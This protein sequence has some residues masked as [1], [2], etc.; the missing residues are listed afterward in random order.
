MNR[1]HAAAILAIGLVCGLLAK[2]AATFM[3]RDTC[4]DSGG[5]WADKTEVCRHK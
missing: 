2:E 1:V 4:L 3:K 5:A